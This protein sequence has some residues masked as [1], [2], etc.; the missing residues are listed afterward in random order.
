VF[1]AVSAAGCDGRIGHKE[2]AKYTPVLSAIGAQCGRM[3]LPE[4]DFTAIKNTITLTPRDGICTGKFLYQLLTHVELPKRG[5]AQP[6]ISKG[7]IQAFPVVVPQSL[8][9]QQRIVDILDQAFAGIATAKANTEKNLQNAR[10]IFDSHLQSVF[11]QRF[12]RWQNQSLVSLCTLFVDSAHRTPKYQVDGIP[13]LRPRDVVNGK[14]NLSRAARVSVEEY[15][16]QSKRHKPSAGDIVY[17]RELSLGWAALLPE[18][19]RVCLS[20][21]MCLFRP[22]P[23][24]D[25]DFLLYALNGSFGRKQ[26]LKVAVGTAHPHINLGDIKSYQIPVPPQDEQKT[27]ARELD[28]LSAETQHLESLYQRKL[29]AL[30]ALKQSLLH[31]AFSGQF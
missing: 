23:E 19:P 24:V 6:F 27:I 10:A 25:S 2:H 26:A 17:S 11:T 20:Q 16:I 15:D 8:R 31:Q 29:G 30:A 7:D 12:A 5:A 3:F 28:V 14:L 1:L 21:G 4:E 22:L 13:A 18:K 9:E